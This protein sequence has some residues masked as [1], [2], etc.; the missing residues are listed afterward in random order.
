VIPPGT[1]RF[2]DVTAYFYT[3]SWL[4]K[5]I[6][7]RGCFSSNKADDAGGLTPVK[8]ENAGRR[9]TDRKDIVFLIMK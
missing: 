2:F 9:K 6:D 8:E 5:R 3:A 7:L 1:K 4:K